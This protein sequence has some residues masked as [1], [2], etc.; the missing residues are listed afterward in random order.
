MSWL[1]WYPGRGPMICGFLIFGH[2][3]PFFGFDTEPCHWDG[4]P[5]TYWDPTTGETDGTHWVPVLTFEWLGIGFSLG[6]T[7]YIR[8][9]K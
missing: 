2:F 8:A 9:K 3:L 6:L 1:Q 4:T 5:P 7:K